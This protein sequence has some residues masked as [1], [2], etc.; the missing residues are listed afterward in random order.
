MDTTDSLLSSLASKVDNIN[1]KILGKDGKPMKAYQNVR[2]EEPI[3]VSEDAPTV[4]ASNTPKGCCYSANG[5]DGKGGKKP[6]SLASILK[7]NPPKK[8]VKISTLSNDENVEGGDVAISLAA[9]DESNMFIEGCSHKIRRQIEDLERAFGILSSSFTVDGVP[10]AEIEDDLKA[11]HVSPR[12]LAIKFLETCVLL[13][14]SDNDSK[15]YI[16]EGISCFS[17]ITAMLFFQHHSLIKYQMFCKDIYEC[18]F[19]MP[20]SRWKPQWHERLRKITDDM[21]ATNREDRAGFVS[22]GEKEARKSVLYAAKVG[23]PKL[24]LV[25]GRKFSSTD[26]R[27]RWPIMLDVYM[28]T[29]CLKSWGRHTYARALI[30]VSSKKALVDSLVVDIPFQ[31]GPGHSKETIDIEYEW[32]TP[33]SEKCKIFDHRD[34][35]CPKQ[36]NDFNPTQV[37]DDE[38]VD[39]DTLMVPVNLTKTE[40][41]LSSYNIID[42]ND[43]EEV[44][45]VFVEDNGKPVD[46]WVD[47]AR[48]KVE[49][50]P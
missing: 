20:T 41:L 34:E 50:P 28:S 19:K 22:S 10:V 39:Q 15:G 11:W 4:E 14:M 38:F 44:E 24:E 46:D 36:A 31:N 21:K 49:V 3:T 6:I 30:D 5:N 43:N 9:I 42:D 25:K 29:M 33:R 23:P 37:L 8:M 1:G 12:L 7:D 45:N 40:L 32:Q 35:Q 16:E 17:S 13:F 48:K 47:D 18:K 27:E 26:K 2:F